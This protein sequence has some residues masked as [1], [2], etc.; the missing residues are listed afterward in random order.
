MQKIKQIQD[1]EIVDLTTFHTL[2]L[3][4]FWPLIRITGLVI[5]GLIIANLIES[6]A[7]A[8]RIIG[9]AA[10]FTKLANLSGVGAAAFSLAFVSGVSANSLLAEAY[11]KQE[12][13][14][15]ELVLA[16]LF[17]SL[18]RFFLHLPTVFFL[19]LPFIHSAAFLYVGLTLL[20]AVI[21][22]LIVIVLGR[23]LLKK[24]DNNTSQ[25]LAEP[26]QKKKSWQTIF[27]RLRKRI[28]KILLFL[29]PI[30]TLFFILNRYG[31]FQALEELIVQKAWFLDWLH[32]GSLGIILLHVTAEF[33]AGLAAASALIAGN[34]MTGEQVVL[35]LMI[36]NLLA[37]PVR[38]I[39][40]QF[41]YYSG[42]YPFKTAIELI[43]LSQTMRAVCII[44]VT[45]GFYSL[46]F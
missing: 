3:E 9:L 38:A 26:K 29:V 32:P 1:L 4:L 5:F 30:Y 34:N 42:I 10:P 37:T 25:N 7:W 40:H 23:L 46:A 19:T 15:R 21:Q 39:R 18:P 16:N 41:P 33:S 14:K 8:K 45:F 17:N 24:P 11:D 2:W 22:T 28:K 27:K 35:A 44:F 43:L 6:M 31:Y 36:G 12:I 20:A 13:T